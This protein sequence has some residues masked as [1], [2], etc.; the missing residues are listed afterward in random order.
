MVADG[1]RVRGVLTGDLRPHKEPACWE[2][3]AHGKSPKESS[4]KTK[5][6]H[7]RNSLVCPKDAHS[8]RGGGGGPG[9]GWEMESEAGRGPGQAGPWR[10]RSGV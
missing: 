6:Q 10:P 7:S 4:K 5:C 9:W 1:R 2:E 3:S 8:P